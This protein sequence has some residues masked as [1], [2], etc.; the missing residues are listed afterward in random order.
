[1]NAKI[2]LRDDD[3]LEPRKRFRGFVVVRNG[4]QIADMP[5]SVRATNV[6][7]FGAWNC[8]V[9]AGDVLTVGKVREKVYNRL[10]LQQHSCGNKTFNEI[11]RAVQPDESTKFLK[12]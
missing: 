3:Q 11:A 12:A 8:D 7:W 4:K 9:L 5:L 1:M 10:F 2:K 6:I